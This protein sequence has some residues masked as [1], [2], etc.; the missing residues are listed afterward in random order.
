V[1]AYG[2]TCSLDDACEALGI[3]RTTAKR[4]LK[5]GRFPVP[6]LP[7]KKHCCYRFSSV[8]LDTYL[9]RA[10]DGLVFTVH[11]GGRRV[12]GAA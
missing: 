8:R 9:A 1:A 5:A 12:R 3:S 6:P 7:R 2:L 4:L 11:R 10:E